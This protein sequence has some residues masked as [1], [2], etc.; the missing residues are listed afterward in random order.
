[1][2]VLRYAR[3]LLYLVYNCA[4]V[5]CARASCTTKVVYVRTSMIRHGSCPGHTLIENLY[6][7]FVV[8]DQI[9]PHHERQLLCTC[10]VYYYR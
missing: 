1:M 4:H 10:T 8:G 5:Q 9:K 7:G 3:L 6:N 2:R